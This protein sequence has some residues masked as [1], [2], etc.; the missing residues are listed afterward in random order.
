MKKNKR[1]GKQKK[2]ERENEKQTIWGLEAR[3]GVETQCPVMRIEG[4]R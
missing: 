4:C 2:R 3:I 1:K